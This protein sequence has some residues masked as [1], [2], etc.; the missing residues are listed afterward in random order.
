MFEFSYPSNVPLIRSIMRV[1]FFYVSVFM[2]F[3][4][5]ILV[6]IGVLF[7]LFIARDLNFGVRVC[8]HFIWWRNRE[9]SSFKCDLCQ[10]N[11]LWSHINS[12]KSINLNRS[13]PRNKR[14]KHRFGETKTE[15]EKN[16]N[17]GMSHK[18]VTVR[19]TVANTNTFYVEITRQLCSL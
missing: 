6:F 18:V 13:I 3:S 8:L 4:L 9:F 10:L 14:L 11:K 16:N 5:F 15:E 2:I 17:D 12:Y 7:Y 19:Y 1:G